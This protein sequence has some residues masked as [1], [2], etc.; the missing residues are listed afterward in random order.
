MLL[1]ISYSYVIACVFFNFLRFPGDIS[2]A[3][4][5]LSTG[6]G[7]LLYAINV[8]RHGNLKLGWLSPTQWLTATAS[9]F[10]ALMAKIP[11]AMNL[12]RQLPDEM[13]ESCFIVTAAARGTPAWVGSEVDPATGVIV[14]QQLRTF[15]L[16]EAWLREKTP[17]FHFYLRRIYNVVGP[18]I[19]GGIWFRW[20]ANMVYCLLKPAEWIARCVLRVV[21]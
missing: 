11:L 7:Y 20:Q 12:F 14:N 17:T 15:R 10:A 19:A 3:L 13:P 6:T 2:L 1:L 16:F 9:I 5:P 21:R 4:V 8:A 18:V